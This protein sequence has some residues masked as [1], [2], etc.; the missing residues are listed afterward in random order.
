METLCTERATADEGFERRKR[1]AEARLKLAF[2]KRH[3]RIV[4]SYERLTTRADLSEAQI[5]AWRERRRAEYRR[6]TGVE[7]EQRDALNT[8]L[9]HI[10]ETGDQSVDDAIDELRLSYAKRLSSSLG[11][12]EEMGSVFA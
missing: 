5:D 8:R 7:I 10:A 2:L 6:A 4:E 3:D 11:G 9:R 1:Q 12:S